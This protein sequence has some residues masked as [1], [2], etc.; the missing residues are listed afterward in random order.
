MVARRLDRANAMALP[1]RFTTARLRAERL[2]SADFAE[3]CRMHCDAAVMAHLGGV[4]DAPASAVY[5]E[6]NLRHWD[7]H[8]FGLWIVYE[9][10][11]SEPIGRAMLRHLLVDQ[12][13]EIEVGYAFY[14]PFWGRGL[15]TEVTLACLPL[16]RT[17]L[18]RSS[19]VA[20]TYPENTHRSTC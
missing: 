7:E 10:D 20:V 5:F 2:T 12:V 8:G 9:R 18:R 13:D 11:G 15:A 6:R 3:I 19:I 4:R 16:A 1:D 17:L 14:E